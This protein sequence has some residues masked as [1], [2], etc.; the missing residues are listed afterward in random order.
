MFLSQLPKPNLF[1]LVV[2]VVVSYRFRLSPQIDMVAPLNSLAGSREAIFKEDD[3]SRSKDRSLGG[4]SALENFWPAQVI[5]PKPI[6]QRLRAA[7]MTVRTLWFIVGLFVY[8][9]RAVSV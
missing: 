7:C 8:L 2:G 1:G 4:F 3:A 9:D 6:G 5:L